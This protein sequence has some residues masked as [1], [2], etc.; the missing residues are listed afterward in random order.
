MNNPENR[1]TGRKKP[2]PPITSF[3]LFTNEEPIDKTFDFKE[4]AVF[5]IDKPKSWSSFRAVGLVR[6]LIG[7]KK[8][9]HAGTLDPMA[10]GLLILCC[11]KATKSIDQVQGQPKT[12]RATIQLGSSTVSYDA[13]TEANES[14]SFEHVNIEGIKTTINDNFLGEIEQEP[15]MYSAIWHKGERLYHIARRGETVERK[16]RNVNIYRFEVVFY[17]K[18]GGIIADIECSKGTY[19]RSLAHDLG[20]KLGTFG[21]LTALRRT[22]IGIFSVDKS[23]TMEKLVTDFDQ[24]GKIDLS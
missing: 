1:Q 21:H 5:L 9:G 16:K 23:I 20:K 24:H 2:A 3:R 6:K 13:E 4:G 11:G 10:T 18:S 22:Q 19:I 15:P 7:I 8:V 12:Y 14:A 17:S